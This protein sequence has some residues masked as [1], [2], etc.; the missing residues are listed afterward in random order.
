MRRFPKIG[1]LAA[2]A[3]ALAMQ[4]CFVRHRMVAPPGKP[5]NRELLTATREDLIARLHAASDPIHSFGLRAD[6]SPSV[7]ALYGGELTDYATIRASIVFRR[8]ADIRVVG[9]DPVVHSKTIFDMVSMGNSF[10]VYIPTKNAFYIGSNTAPPSSKNKLEN[11]RP[12]AFLTSLILAPPA[13]SDRTM[14]GDNT[15]ETKAQYILF[16][17]RENQGQLILERSVYFDRYTLTIV[18]QKTFD[19][20][21]AVV[22]ETRYSDWKG[23]DG[24][25]FP[26]TI[27]IRRPKDG[28]EMTMTIVSLRFNQPDVSAEQFVLEQPPGVKVVEIK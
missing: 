22:S 8:P 14:I 23:F 3:S 5:P 18:M 10:K 15:D 13:A 16:M 12:T 26:S 4:A 11:L 7:G 20:S 19:E 25:P 17:I 27:V 24:I 6:L 21:G 28:Y 1:V 2:L 9:L